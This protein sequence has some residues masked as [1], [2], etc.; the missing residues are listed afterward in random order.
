MTEPPSLP[1]ADTLSVALALPGTAPVIEGAPAGPNGMTELLGEEAGPVPTALVAVTVNVY[2]VPFASPVT[3]CVMA[4]VPALLSTP[5]A[6]LATTVYP[7][8][9]D[10]PS[11]AGGENATTAWALP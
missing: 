7:V 6:G 8:I 4:V 11:L 5:P 9:G 2:D 10:P 1:G 3:T